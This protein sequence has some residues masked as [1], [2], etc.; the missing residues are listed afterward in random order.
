MFN[1]NGLKYFVLQKTKTGLPIEEDYWTPLPPINMDFASLYQYVIPKS[2]MEVFDRYH[3]MPYLI[4]T[5]DII[6]QQS[7]SVLDNLFNELNN[8]RIQ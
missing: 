6:T 7:R 1:N 4:E 5:R 2:S 3:I 8:L